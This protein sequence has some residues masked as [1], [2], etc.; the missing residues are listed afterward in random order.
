M[1]DQAKIKLITIGFILL[2]GFTL[3]KIIDRAFRERNNIQLKF[4]KSIL[5][6][7]VIIICGYLILGQF[8]ITNGTGQALIQSSALILAVATFAAQKTLGNV[9]SG[10][11]ISLT[12]PCD[13]GQKIKIMSGSSL[14]AE[15]IVKDMTIRHI[16]VDQYDGQSCIIP[17][18]VIDN[19]VIVNT[20][21]EG[22]VGNY[23]EFE[24]GY[25][26]DLDKAKEILRNIYV[27][28]KYTIRKESLSIFLSRYTANGVVLKFTAW[29]K[30]LDDSYK[31]CSE[32][33]EEVLKQFKLNSIDI[34]YNIINIKS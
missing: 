17:N 3:L 2:F 5:K 20:N 16:V 4:L 13:I 8:T 19:A 14:I 1:G 11:S 12:K 33:R 25:D 18:S 31:A 24:I 23:M 15:G 34:P 26:S 21:Y 30:N 6:G 32:I 29:S 7:I 10:F 27:N 28:N 22:D 9:I